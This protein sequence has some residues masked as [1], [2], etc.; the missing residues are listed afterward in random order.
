LLGFAEDLV[1]GGQGGEYVGGDEAVADEL[2]EAFFALEEGFVGAA[3]LGEAAFGD[4]AA[5]AQGGIDIAAEE[6]G[7]IDLDFSR[8]VSASLISSPLMGPAAYLGNMMATS[9]QTREQAGQ[10][11]LQLS[12]FWT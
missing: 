3:F 5:G 8:L 10:L 2:G 9:G 7:D 6:G 12:L 4:F 11:V 1:G